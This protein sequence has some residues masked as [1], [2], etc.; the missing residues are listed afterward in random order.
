MELATIFGTLA[1]IFTATRFIPQVFK[2]VKTKRTRDLSLT[3]LYFVGAQSI[4]LI[5]YGMTKPDQFVLYMNI[6]PLMCVVFLIYLKLRC[7]E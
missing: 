6:F 3:F 5:L 1:S 2:S 4:F 7:G